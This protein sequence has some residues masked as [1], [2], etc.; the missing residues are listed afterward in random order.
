MDV[1]SMVIRSLYETRG[2]KAY[3]LKLL[4][5]TLLPYVE[6]RAVDYI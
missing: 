4:P 2:R 3:L 1:S 5:S 6:S